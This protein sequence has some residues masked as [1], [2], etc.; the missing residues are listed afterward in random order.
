MSI[1]A[2]FVK[3]LAKELHSELLSGR[4]QKISQLSKTDFLFLVRANN[5]NQKLYISLS[6]SLAR[7]NITNRNYDSDFIPGGYCMFLRKFIEGGI[8]KN[9]QARNDDRIVDIE[10]ESKN[11]IGDTTTIYLIIEMFSR[12]TNMIILNEEQKIINA[13]KHISPFEDT[14]RTIANGAKYEL[15]SDQRIMQEDLEKIKIFFSE[16]R[17][18]KDI[19]NNIRGLSPLLAR[20]MVNQATYNH[21]KMYQVYKDMLDEKICP[22][23]HFGNKTQFYYFDLFKDKKKHYE[24]LS[25]LLDNYFLEASAIERVKQVYKYINTFTKQDVKRKKHKLEKLDVDLTKAL[26]NDVLRIKG[27]I[28]IANQHQMYKGDAIFKGYSYELEKELE[29]ELDR[30]LTPIQN[31]NKYYTKYKK[32]KKAVSYILQQIKI[33]KEQIT[34][35][36]EIRSQINNTHSLS[37]LLEI[38]E[39]LRDNGFLPRKKKKNSKKQKPNFDIYEDSIGIKIYVGKNNLQNNYLTH[40]YAKK[41]YWWFHTKEQSGSHVIV[42]SE[43]DSLEE[44][45]IRTAANL[46]A[47]FSKAKQSSSVPIDYTKIKNIK[48]IPKMFG[49]Y[50]TYTNQKTIYIDPNL[51]EIDQLKKGR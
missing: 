18:H 24:T 43:A 27:D 14:E 4:I 21:L 16:E 7:I 32:Q 46:S 49:S 20:Y 12:Y 50:V 44:A 2:R 3:F 47:C 40:K 42:A 39:E 1:D 51:D 36:D 15:P 11:E 33:T 45:S 35:L 19:I 8:I 31:A 6:T 17:T 26:N 5:K 30:L 25:E 13:Y 28:L 48:K 22:T 29:I 34:Y 10:V 23:I 41:E 38:Q 37:D 9:I